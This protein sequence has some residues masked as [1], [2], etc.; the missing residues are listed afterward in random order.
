MFKH[1]DFIFYHI[2]TFSL[3][4][5][6]FRNDY[7]Q[8]GHKLD[9]IAKWIPHIKSLGCNA[10]LLSPV[11]K[12][13]SHGYDVTDYFQ[14]DNR[15]GTNT[16][17]KELVR[18][19]HENGICLVLD[20]VFNHCGRDFFAF[21][22]LRQG[23]RE[24]ATWFSGVDFGRQSPAGDYFTYDC[25]SGHY[26]LVKFN[27]RNAKTREYLLGAAR[28]WI[29]EFDIDG[30]RLDSANVMDFDFMR[31]LRSA[32]TSIKPDFW[33]MGEVVAGNYPQWVNDSMLHSVTG[34]QLY[35]SLFSSHN[36]NNMYE[37][38]HTVSQ[39][40]PNN[41]LPHYNFLDNH[42]QPR[43]IDNVTNPAFLKTLYPLLYTLPGI[44]SIYYGS[45]W[46]IHGKKEGG[47][48]QPLRPYIDI[49]NAPADTD[50]TRL[51]RKLAEIRSAHPALKYGSYQQVY[52]QY[53][54][55]FVFERRF[56]GERILVAVNISDSVETVNAGE[57]TMC[58]LLSGETVNTAELTIQPH[59]AM[60]C[61]PWPIGQIEH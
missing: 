42:D 21:E 41:G 22:E 6:P 37:L 20:S 26:E 56:E 61:S 27:L 54:R 57:A 36:S 45:E 1:N 58:D 52:L 15:I 12:S 8:T 19:F 4:G 49:G 33:L 50:V 35:K 31:D 55:P 34:Y 7:S 40:A 46:E 5:A 38:A 39:S 11:L 43:I 17:F 3:A 24:N 14:I 51:I 2:Y 32:A 28:F 60:I 44:P 18:R 30:M 9:E 13:M 53:R 59:S 10:V 25:W 48:D 16:E 23:K 29:E 47:S